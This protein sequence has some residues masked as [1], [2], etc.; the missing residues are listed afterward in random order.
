MYPGTPREDG[1]GFDKRRQV[2]ESAGVGKGAFLSHRLRGES[3]LTTKI[4]KNPKINA[5][6]PFL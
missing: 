1:F 4:A 6:Q 5:A 2:E 3:G